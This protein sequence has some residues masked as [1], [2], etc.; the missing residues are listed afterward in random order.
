MPP[1]KIDCLLYQSWL[2]LGVKPTPKLVFHTMVGGIRIRGG[3]TT[4]WAGA[5]AARTSRFVEAVG[6]GLL[7][8]CRVVEEGDTTLATA[9]FTSLAAGGRAPVCEPIR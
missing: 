4:T 2:V 1:E 6:H 5:G 8:G 3:S 7:R 9:V